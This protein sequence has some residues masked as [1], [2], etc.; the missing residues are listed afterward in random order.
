V[1]AGGSEVDY[2]GV[3][4]SEEMRAFTAAGERLA[5]L[6]P[7]ELDP[8]GGR[9][10]FWINLYNILVIQRVGDLGIATRVREAGNFFSGDACVVGGLA[11]SLD[12]I[13]YG[14]LR[15]NIR[16]RFHPGRQLRSW[17]RRRLLAPDPPD[18]CVFAALVKGARSG[19]PLRFYESEEVSGQLH[20]AAADFI[21]ATGVLIDRE[22]RTIFLSRLFRDYSAD[23]GG[24]Q[25]VMRFI[26]GQLRAPDDAALIRTLTSSYRVRYQDFDE[27]LNG[28]KTAN[29]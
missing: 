17:D 18:P 2:G 21:N 5:G 11:F 3:R 27:S 20:S 25:G 14:V 15:A 16:R 24:D 22:Q 7:F 23:F 10:A 4:D 12:D 9:L 29:N 28:P 13:E 6:N 19:P 26:A 1:S 8:A